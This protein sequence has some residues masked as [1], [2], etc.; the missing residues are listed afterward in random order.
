MLPGPMRELGITMIALG[1]G[2]HLGALFAPSSW[3]LGR[4][5]MALLMLGAPVVMLRMWIDQRQERLRQD[6]TDVPPPEQHG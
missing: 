4:W 1:L 3:Q 2:A 6:G 5:G